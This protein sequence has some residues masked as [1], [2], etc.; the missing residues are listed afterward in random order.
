M[1]AAHTCD[2][3]YR[4]S[5][6]DSTIAATGIPRT[7]EEEMELN[8]TALRGNRILSTIQL[9]LQATGVLLIRRQIR[10]LWPHS[11]CPPSERLDGASPS[12]ATLAAKPALRCLPL[13]P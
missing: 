3:I 1:L 8:R 7:N 4:R 5:E 13:P 11:C 9:F 10:F 2:L 6:E 12:V